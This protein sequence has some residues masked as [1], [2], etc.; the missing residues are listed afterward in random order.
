[1]RRRSKSR[2]C[3]HGRRVLALF[4]IDMQSSFQSHH[5]R[6]HSS[7]PPPSFERLT[8]PCARITHRATPWLSDESCACCT[9]C[10]RRFEN[11]GSALERNRVPRCAACTESVFSRDGSNHSGTGTV[12]SLKDLEALGCDIKQ[13]MMRNS[14]IARLSFSPL[15]GHCWFLSRVALPTNRHFKLF[16]LVLFCSVLNLDHDDP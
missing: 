1:M 7:H 13:V 5:S 6:A 9:T 15:I 4:S 8:V 16:P 14:S 2:Q 3:I 12:V 11:L 10:G